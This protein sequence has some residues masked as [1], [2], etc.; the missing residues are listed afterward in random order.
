MN[1]GIVVTRLEN[2]PE[3]HKNEHEPY[4]YRRYEVTP[5]Q[6]FSGCYAAFYE[7]PPRKYSYPYHYHSANTE[8]FYIIRGQGILETPEGECTVQAGDVV[9]CPP[10]EAGAHRLF[11]PSV[12]ET[13]LYLDCDA[14]HSP[15]VIRYPRSGKTGIILHGQSSTFFPDCSAASYYDG[16]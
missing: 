9:A 3:S 11:N 7:I 15:E 4:E 12:T 16:E 5:R 13:L 6:D 2:L 14:V 10:G 1:K 8:L